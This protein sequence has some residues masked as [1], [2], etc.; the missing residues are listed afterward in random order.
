MTSQVYQLCSRACAG[1]MVLSLAAGDL[2][3]APRYWGPEAEGSVPLL[4]ADRRGRRQSLDSAVG[5]AQRTTGGRVLSAERV[6]RDGRSVYRVKVLTQDGRVRVI[7][8]DAGS[9][10]RR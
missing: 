4:L 6:E 8:S 10:D 7:E 9:N 5:D 2:W 3:A 1:L